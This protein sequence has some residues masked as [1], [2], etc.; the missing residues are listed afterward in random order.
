[1]SSP[2]TLEQ[3][4]V[5]VELASAWAD[6]KLV[7]IGAAALGCHVSMTWRRTNDIDLT[8]VADIAS[9]QAAL[10]KLGFRRHEKQEHRWFSSTGVALDILPV[11]REDFASRKLEWPEGGHVMELQSFDLLLK[12]T[13]RFALD[14]THTLEIAIVPVIV[15]L[16]MRLSRRAPQLQCSASTRLRLLLRPSPGPRCHSWLGP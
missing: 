9:T 8:V 2:F 15:I 16:K 6:R 12:H 11:T 5:L 14:N 1:M 10:H 4:Q 13:Q 7:L 3:T